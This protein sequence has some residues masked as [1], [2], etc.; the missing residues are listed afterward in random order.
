MLFIQLPHTWYLS[1]DMQL[2]LVA[3]FIVL[4]INWFG[5]FAIFALV[6]MICGCCAW[7]VIVHVDN[8]FKSMYV[9]D[10]FVGIFVEFDHFQEFTN[11]NALYSLA[12]NK[13]QVAYV[14]THL[15]FSSWLVGFIAG[16]IFLK[17]QKR[18]IRIPRV[19]SRKILI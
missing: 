5:L 12:P 9:I 11:N 17:F 16:Y 18:S 7:T 6:L 10:F 2:F 13:F 19:R 8:G 3:P 4:L 15:R 1:V 14:P